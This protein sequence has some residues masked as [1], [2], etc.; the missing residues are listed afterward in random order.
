[1]VLSTLGRRYGS[2]KDS[3]PLT[4]VYVILSGQE[5]RAVRL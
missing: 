2:A 1:M 3:E 4:L 5:I